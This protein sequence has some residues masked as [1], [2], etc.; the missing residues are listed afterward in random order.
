MKLFC[1]LWCS[2]AALAAAA[3]ASVNP[4]LHQVKRVYILAM[5]SG[6][7]QYPGEPAHQVRH[8]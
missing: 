5:G 4:E 7:D 8:L 1:V 6:M 3:F 2:L